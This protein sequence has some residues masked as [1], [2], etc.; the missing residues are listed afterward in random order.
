MADRLRTSRIRRNLVQYQMDPSLVVICSVSL[1]DR[2]TA[3]LDSHERGMLCG[4][5]VCNWERPHSWQ[6]HLSSRAPTL[7]HSECDLSR[8]SRPIASAPQY[9]HPSQGQRASFDSKSATRFSS[10]PILSGATF[11]CSHMSRTKYSQTG[12]STFA[13]LI[14]LPIWILS[15]FLKVAGG[16]VCSDSR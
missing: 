7:P 9:E 6:R 4:Y 14:A 11:N 10:A 16:I 5:T 3:L 8:V 13:S 1:E 15:W 2:D 12:N